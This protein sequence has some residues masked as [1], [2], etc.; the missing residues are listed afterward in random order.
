MRLK[1]FFLVLP[2]ICTS[3]LAETSNKNNYP[4]LNSTEIGV[5]NITYKESLS[6]F[7]GIGDLSTE[8]EVSNTVITASSYTNLSEKWGFLLNSQ[9]NATREFADDEWKVDGFGKVLS[10]S[11]KIGINE[12]TAQGVYHLDQKT[13]LT[14]GGQLKTLGFVRSNFN[15]IGQA[16]DLNKAIRESDRYF[17]DSNPPQIIEER[18]AIEEDLTFINAIAGIHYNTAFSAERK[19]LTWRAGAVLSTPLLYSAKNTS[20]EQQLGVETIDDSFTGYELRLNAGVSYELVAGLA[21]TLSADYSMAEHDEINTKATDPISGNE[22]TAAIPE[23]EQTSLQ[24][25]LGLLWIN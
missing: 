13:Y 22:R 20:L 17:A 1:P 15:P 4:G 23:I 14:V 10:N 11:N 21:L 12:L 3:V 6:D 16:S 9:S 5:Q 7:A 25:T 8:V 19:R 24:F 2:F 18:Y